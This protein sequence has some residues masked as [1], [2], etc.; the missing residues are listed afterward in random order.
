[1]GIPR[2]TSVVVAALCVLG[3]SSAAAAKP[4]HA[5]RH[6]ATARH[7]GAKRLVRRRHKHVRVHGPLM[8]DLRGAP[9]APAITGVTYYVSAW[10]SDANSGLS[11]GQAWRT[12]GRVNAARLRP[13]DG[14]LFQAGQVFSDQ[15]L[16][17]ASSGSF[18][19]PIVFGSYGRGQATLS[20]GAWFV[21]HDLAFEKL[22]FTSTFYGGSAFK[23]P[24]DDITLDGVTI[25]LSPG[26][27]ALGLYANGQHWVIENSRITNTGLSGM[28]LNGDDYLITNN[29]LDHTGL[30]TT[31]GYNNHGIYLDA[32]NA[33]ITANTITNFADSAI[34]VRYRNSRIS[35]N[36]I[37]GGQIGID[38][39]QTDSTPGTSTWTDN[40][41][42][43]TTVASIFI[44]GT[45]EGCHQPLESFT[46]T[47]N[48]L[49]KT[50]GVY[51]N[52]QPTAGTY[53]LAGNELA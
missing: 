6:R 20:K 19:A 36:T 33:T 37:S 5:P 23:G 22:A 39:Y 9:G 14:V 29:V 47:S 41:I 43:H 31:N 13:G 38:Y 8:H 16:M 35:A 30:D 26:N 10:G 3:A 44:C 50:A 2:P 24:S 4:A 25:S 34:S 53:T 45:A 21:K 28:L 7:A 27:Q 42:S 32:S 48:R 52:L 11:P 49:T 51:M 12:V 17:P 15:E 46:I 18:G 1:M 40:A